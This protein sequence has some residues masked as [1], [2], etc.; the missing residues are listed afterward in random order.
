D[1]EEFSSGTVYIDDERTEEIINESLVSEA[2]RAI[3]QERK[4]AGLEVE[5]RVDLS[6]KGDIEPLKKNID[7]LKN[8]INLSDVSFGEIKYSY[9][10]EVELK[11]NKI[12]YSFR[13]S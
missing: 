6:F 5:D 2:V 12:K 7:R 8:R 11:G 13:K 9:S 4:E 1:G 3:Q 10:G